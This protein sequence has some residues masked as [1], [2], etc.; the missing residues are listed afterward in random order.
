MVVLNNSRL[1]VGINAESYYSIWDAE[2]WD[3]CYGVL[4][5]DC[6]EVNIVKDGIMLVGGYI[7]GDWEIYLFHTMK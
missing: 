2:E 3:E 7:C 1:A 5:L 6:V 4:Q